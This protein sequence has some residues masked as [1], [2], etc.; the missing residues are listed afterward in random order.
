MR[1]KA[2]FFDVGGTLIFPNL[3]ELI[4]PLL[5]RGIEPTAEQLFT[6]DTAAKHLHTR[7]SDDAP[8]NRSHWYVYFSS[9]LD[10]IGA[11]RDLLE[12]LATR[13]GDS[14]YW[15]VVAPGA[16]ETLQRLSTTYR[17]A[18]ISNADGKTRQVLDNAGLASYFE[19][20]TDSG[21]AGYEK[22]DRR[23]FEAA[24]RD[25]QLSPADGLYVGDIY[26]VDYV[27]ATGAGMQAVVIDFPGIYRASSF[28]RVKSLEELPSYIETLG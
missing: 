12:E 26:G 15:T 2:I 14:S 20:I 7:G 3:S 28:P 11:G 23:I 27:G 21:L 25:M 8:G 13:A 19:S 1:P 5:R 10:Q 4:A 9:L 24:L 6:A 22:P 16:A 17:L 18:V